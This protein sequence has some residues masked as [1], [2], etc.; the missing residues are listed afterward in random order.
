MNGDTRHDA[1]A[2]IG[3]LAAAAG[4]R[5]IHVLCWRDLDDVEAGGSEVYTA[6]VARLW[7]EAGL[8]V[9]VRSSFAQG[10]PRIVDRDGYRVVRKAGRYLVFPRSVAAEL[11]GRMGPRDAVVEHWN[12]LPFLSPLWERN[13]AIAVLHHVH[14]EMWKMVLGDEAPTLARAGELFEARVAPLVY[15][16]R[17]LV[18]VSQSSKDEIV[19]RLHIR[20]ERI[21]VVSPGIDEGFVPGGERS[22]HP[23]VTAV[24]RLVPVKN[25]DL[26]LRACAVAREAIPDLTLS[27]VG[28]GYERGRLDDLVRE[29]DAEQWVTFTGHLREDELI[30]LYQRSWVV[31]STSSHEGWGMTLT[32]AAACGTPAVATRIAGHADSVVDGTSGLLVDGRAESFAGGLTRVLGDQALR[33][34]LAAGALERAT[35]LTWEATASGLMRAL[36][37]DS[38]RRR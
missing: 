19:S 1:I 3:D 35:E 14:G 22:P 34:R 32:E 12:G 36:A 23:H 27:I 25:H 28:Q 26:L 18:T 30:D 9:T 31:A 8:E 29:L 6:H 11:A 17:G 5:R 10:Q 37:A 38:A 7:A 20:P 13:A 2:K 21:T 15:R 24:G 4:L 33:Q 16:R